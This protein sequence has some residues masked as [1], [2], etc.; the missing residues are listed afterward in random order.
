MFNFTLSNFFNAYKVNQVFF[1]LVLKN[2][3]Y[4]KESINFNQISGTFPFNSWGGSYNNC[5]NENILLSH[6]IEKFFESYNKVLRINFSN[7]NLKEKDFYN[8]YNRIIL[9]KGQ[10]GSTAIEIA[11]FDLYFYIKKNYPYYNNF[12][13][14][15]NA[16][17]IIDF[18]PE[19]INTVLENPDFK[20]ISLPFK[21][22]N[23]FDYINQIENKEKIE[24]CINPKCPI[25][26]KNYSKCIFNENINQ[27]EFS[28]KSVFSECQK[29]YDYNLNP[30]DLSL[31]DLKENYLKRGINHFK[32]EECFNYQTVQYFLFLIKYFIK[33]EYQPMLI[34]KGLLFI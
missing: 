15:S 26:C 20:L 30:Q 22:S 4:F 3:Y 21:L 12:I 9:E 19:A 24:I 31:K 23:D 27:Y 29:C 17:E 1:D 14:S 18:S 10:N 7:I 16:W 5:L 8:N 2:E 34:E 28:K 13:L 6:E 11:N 33:E 32:L 25:S